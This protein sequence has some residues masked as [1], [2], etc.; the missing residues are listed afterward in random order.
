MEIGKGDAFW[1]KGWL[2]THAFSPKLKNG[3]EDLPADLLK[4]TVDHGT[5]VGI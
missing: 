1:N 4:W 2:V 5:K 3:L